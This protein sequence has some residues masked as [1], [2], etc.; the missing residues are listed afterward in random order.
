ML[1]QDTCTNKDQV[2]AGRCH[3]SVEQRLQ[4]AA[5]L[6]CRK[7]FRR[8]LFPVVLLQGRSERRHRVDGEVCGQKH[9]P[10]P[11]TE[12]H[13][14]KPGAGTSD[15]LCGLFLFRLSYSFMWGEAE[16]AAA[17]ARVWGAS[18][19]NPDSALLRLQHGFQS[20]GCLV[21]FVPFEQ[22]LSWWSVF[23]LLT[24]SETCDC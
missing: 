24:C 8:T 5:V 9:P 7:S 1:D 10:A 4:T 17:A 13:H 6:N 12:G 3:R 16:P 2:C 21:T 18:L 11:Q 20:F 15:D 14:L 19:T 23:N 22:V